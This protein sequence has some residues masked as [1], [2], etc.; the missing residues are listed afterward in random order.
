M[1]SRRR[2]RQFAVQLLYQ[3]SFSD[4]APEKVFTLFWENS[5]NKAGESTRDFAQLLV[6]GVMEN[7]FELDMEISAYLKNWTLDRIA[8]LDHIILRIALFE[9]LH[10]KDVP[11]K[12]VIDEAVNLAKLFSSEKSATFINGVLHAWATRNRAKEDGE[13]EP[14]PPPTEEDAATSATV[15]TGET[16]A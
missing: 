4:Y 13:A 9:L 14:D 1:T 15:E 11:W 2:G 3:Q 10:S 6:N 16:P 12:V 8:V 5:Q 7:R